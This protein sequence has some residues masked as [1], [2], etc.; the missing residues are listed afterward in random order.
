VG[1]SLAATA[2]AVG[3]SVD[4]LRQ[5]SY[6]LSRTL[7]WTGGML[8]PRAKESW[9]LRC[10][11]LR[12]FSH[13]RRRGSRP[14]QKRRG[15]GRTAVRSSPGISPCRPGRRDSWSRRPQA[16]VDV[17]IASSSVPRPVRR[18]GVSQSSRFVQVEVKQVEAGKAG[19]GA[20]SEGPEE[21]RQS[22][23]VKVDGSVRGRCISNVGEDGGCDEDIDVEAR[24]IPRNKSG[25]RSAVGG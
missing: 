1:L 16:T 18:R 3:C 13:W 21:E 24:R 7:S 11:R 4:L 15:G 10:P 23:M 12:G 9:R 22:G 5:F 19:P 6:W 2:V 17:I 20:Q 8:P 14:L 25:R